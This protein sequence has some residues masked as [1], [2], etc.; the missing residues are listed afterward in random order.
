[1]T[2][3]LN[4]MMLLNAWL[5][6]ELVFYFRNPLKCDLKFFTISGGCCGST[7]KQMVVGGW[8]WAWWLVTD[9]QR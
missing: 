7:N 2:L 5:I 1:M 3:T 9:V 6:I 8:A 4:L